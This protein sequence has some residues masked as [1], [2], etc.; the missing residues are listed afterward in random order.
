MMDTRAKNDKK[1]LRPEVQY[2]VKQFNPEKKRGAK[3][4]SWMEPIDRGHYDF[5]LVVVVGLTVSCLY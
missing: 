4:V 5:L 1:T 2:Y 3:K